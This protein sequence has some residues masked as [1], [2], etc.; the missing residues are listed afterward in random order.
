[1]QTQIINFAHRGINYIL[2]SCGNYT[3]ILVVWLLTF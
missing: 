2:L 1:M 3:T